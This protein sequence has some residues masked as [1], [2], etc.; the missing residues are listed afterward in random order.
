MMPGIL[1]VE[2]AKL[3]REARDHIAQ[4]P[5]SF[6]WVNWCGSQCCISGH[7]NLALDRRANKRDSDS[8]W[9]YSQVRAANA[10]GFDDHHTVP[11]QN[12]FYG[13]RRQGDGAP[14]RDDL[15]DVPYAIEVINV[16]LVKHGHPIDEPPDAALEMQLPE[17]EF[18]LCFV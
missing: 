17:D 3:L 18:E 16:F 12:L 2:G 13:W 1:T 11:V 4:H 6:N 5:E 10:L 7:I 8:W 9:A 14:T 15:V